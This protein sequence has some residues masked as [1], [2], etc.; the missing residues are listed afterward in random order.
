V[1]F[2][3]TRVLRLL[4][5]A[6]CSALSKKARIQPYHQQRHGTEAFR[7]A[8][9]KLS[10]Q[11]KLDWIRSLG[12][13][14]VSLRRWQDEIYADLGGEENCSAMERVIVDAATKTVLML[15][16]IDSF[17]LAQPS[18][19]NKTRRQLFF[20]VTQRTTLV[21]T[22]AQLMGQ[23]GLKRRPKP[24]PSVHEYLAGP[25]EATISVAPDA[26]GTITDPAP[27]S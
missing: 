7:N 8:I 19:I 5:K 10:E 23:L 17:L 25:G 26:D 9:T 6:R 3:A 15:P 14:G 12:E 1:A 13:L 16:H 4:R 22:L 11:G 2:D 20:I 24:L 21:N 18:L 27:Q